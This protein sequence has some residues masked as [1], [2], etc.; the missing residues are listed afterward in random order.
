M[1]IVQS[2]ARQALTRPEAIA[3]L[4]P[5]GGLTYAQTV[6]TVAHLASG[7]AQLGVKRGDV[8]AISARDTM[9]HAWLTMAIAWVGGVSVS[10]AA[11]TTPEDKLELATRCGATFFF[12]G[13]DDAVIQIPGAPTQSIRALLDRP[14]GPVPPI[15]SMEPADIWRIGF[16]SGTTGRPKAIR[17]SHEAAM[18]RN[19]L[20]VSVIPMD[21]GDRVLV[22]MGPGLVFA[23]TYWLR[24]LCCGA[25]VVTR[26]GDAVK[27]WDAIRRAGVSFMVTSP[28]NA[29]TLAKAAQS[30][31]APAPSL[32]TLLLGGAP[33][34]VSQ[35][36]Q[37]RKHLCRNIIVNYGA[38]E[39]GL[40]AHLDSELMDKDP[41]CAGRV[42][43]WIDVE[44]VDEQG[45]VIPAGQPGRG[46][47]RMRARTMASGYILPPGA[48]ESDAQAFRD[49]WFYSKDVGQVSR[50]GLVRLAG[51]AGD[52]INLNGNK[53][54][55]ADVE[56]VLGA[57][58][59]VMDCVVVQARRGAAAVLVAVI[60]PQAPFEWEELQRRCAPKLTPAQMPTAC[61]IAESLPRN[62]AGK[63][64]RDEV[65][66]GLAG[67]AFTVAKQGAPAGIA[68]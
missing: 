31:G 51:R 16:S 62:A 25:T 37:F 56:S 8:V 68:A 40:V 28:G 44:A 63:I 32:K 9:P 30:S 59:E 38:T 6:S 65:A 2:F 20:P 13:A 1:N 4:T 58:P 50:D 43:P 34:T 57:Q 19:L 46:L 35:R 66:R 10:V 49:G 21:Q 12:H 29:I 55:P 22:D 45:Q 24:A 11:V 60:V 52:V 18:L 61:L 41:S 67:K 5:Q 36:D 39:V 53:V 15:A 54:D 3:F 48:D 64:M 17:F 14:R 23:L 26:A 7:M 47:L 42:P 33:V 27:T